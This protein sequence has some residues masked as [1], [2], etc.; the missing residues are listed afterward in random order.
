MKLARFSLFSV[1]LAEH[2]YCSLSTLLLSLGQRDCNLQLKSVINISL[3]FFQEQ[4]HTFSWEE[5]QSWD[6]DEEGMSL[7]FSFERA[8]KKLRQVRV[9]SK[10]V[11]SFFLLLMIDDRAFSANLCQDV[12]AAQSPSQI[13]YMLAYVNNVRLCLYLVIFAHKCANSNSIWNIVQ[14]YKI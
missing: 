14:H 10:Y 2:G 11:S 7:I 13:C 3:D 12:Q 6:A 1:K 5:I 8:G 4:E 9:L